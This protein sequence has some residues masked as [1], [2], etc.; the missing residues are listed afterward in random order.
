VVGVRRG[1]RRASKFGERGQGAREATNLLSLLA[2]LVLGLLAVKLIK[3]CS[4]EEDGQQVDGGVSNAEA[5][6][7]SKLTLGLEELVGLGG[8]ES[9]KELLLLTVKIEISVALVEGEEERD[10]PWR[11]GG[12]EEG[13]S[14]RRAARKPWRPVKVE[15]QE[16]QLRSPSMLALRLCF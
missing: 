9:S 15:R 1:Q 7:M 16:R 6:A 11:A 13:R 8:S 10:E 14:E 2:S 4:R 3:T 12:K 5:R